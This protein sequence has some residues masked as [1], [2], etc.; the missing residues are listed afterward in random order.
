MSG[1]DVQDSTE[2]DIDVESWRQAPARMKDK[3]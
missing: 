1:C 3:N 2:D